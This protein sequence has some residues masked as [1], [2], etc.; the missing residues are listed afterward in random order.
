MRLLLLLAAVV[1]VHLAAV[2][3]SSLEEVFPASGAS[4]LAAEVYSIATAQPDFNRTLGA[5]VRVDG[6]GLGATFL[7]FGP[8]APWLPLIV[9]PGA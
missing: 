6:A 4:A 8:V 9:P 5:R 3:G 2:H 1:V 7:D